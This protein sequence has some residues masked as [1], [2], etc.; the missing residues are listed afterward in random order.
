VVSG[1][2]PN[3]P[4][5]AWRCRTDQ[6]S[7]IGVEPADVAVVASDDAGELGQGSPHGGVV[8]AKRLRELSVGVGSFVPAESFSGWCGCGQGGAGSQRSGGGQGVQGFAQRCGSGDEQRVQ[9]VEQSGAGSHELGA[10]Y[11]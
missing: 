5:S 8:V 4:D 2:S 9:G 3:S 7:E 1:P 11:P 6:D 10:Q